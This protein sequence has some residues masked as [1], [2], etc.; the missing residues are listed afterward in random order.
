MGAWIGRLPHTAAGWLEHPD[1]VLREATVNLVRSKLPRYTCPHCR[2][3]K[4]SLIEDNGI[5]MNDPD[6]TLLCM[7]LV[8]PEDEAIQNEPRQK[9]NADDLVKCG[10]T[11]CPNQ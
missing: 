1:D 9:P 4:Q 11:W 5:P 6:Y 8:K 2:N 10:M 7:A 3:A